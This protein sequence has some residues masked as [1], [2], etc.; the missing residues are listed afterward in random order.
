ML[1]LPFK[2]LLLHSSGIEQA[3]HK[4]LK[5]KKTRAALCD[6]KA[7]F[8]NIT[9]AAEIRDSLDDLYTEPWIRQLLHQRISL[10]EKGCQKRRYYYFFK[11]FRKQIKQ[12]AWNHTFLYSSEF[13]IPKYQFHTILSCMLQDFLKTG[14]FSPFFTGADEM[15][16]I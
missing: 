9:L 4:T 14:T 16:W 7:A 12:L 6:S 15:G 1:L 2:M 13:W 8:V 3:W 5:K 10:T 11:D